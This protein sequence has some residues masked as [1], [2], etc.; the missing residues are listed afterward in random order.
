[1]NSTGEILLSSILEKEIKSLDIKQCV[2]NPSY[3]LLRGGFPGNQNSAD[4]QTKMQMCA[5]QR[6]KSSF[7]S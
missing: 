2:A 1:M 5:F 3:K 6:T 4:V 7:Y